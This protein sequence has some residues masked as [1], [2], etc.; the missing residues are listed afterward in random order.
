MPYAQL[1]SDTGIRFFISMSGFLKTIFLTPTHFKELLGVKI[2]PDT[3][4][5]ASC[6][7]Q[8]PFPT[9]FLS[10][11]FSFIVISIIS[12]ARDLDVWTCSGLLFWSDTFIENLNFFQVFD[13]ILNLL[14]FAWNS[15][16]MWRFHNGHFNII[17]LSFY[18]VVKWT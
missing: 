11:I 1:V 16:Y 3:Q 13:K 14:K 2:F 6:F 18:L 12:L 15:K 17:I 10:G 4:Y 8:N 5:P 7:C 9:T